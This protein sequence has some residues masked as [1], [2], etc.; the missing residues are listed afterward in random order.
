MIAK[1]KLAVIL[2]IV[3]IASVGSVAAVYYGTNM[4]PPS[5]PVG[6]NQIVLKYGSAS[7]EPTIKEGSYILIDKDINPADLNTNYPNSDIIVFHDPLDP[8]L[9]LGHRIINL[10]VVNGTM[11][12]LTKGDANG[13]PYPQTPQS[14][15]DTWDYNTPPGVPKDMVVGKVVNTNYK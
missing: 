6:K 2:L 3:L 12:F 4:I 1:K 11:Y 14:G 7:M 15:L 13:N 10:T 8:N 9:L 5:F